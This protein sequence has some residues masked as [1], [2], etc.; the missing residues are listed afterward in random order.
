MVRFLTK[1]DGTAT[2]REGKRLFEERAKEIDDQASIVIIVAGRTT[3]LTGAQ[4]KAS[5]YAG[6]KDHAKITERSSVH[7][8]QIFGDRAR[9]EYSSEAE[10]F[11]PDLN[12]KRLVRD[13][14]TMDIQKIG[15]RLI[16]T[17]WRSELF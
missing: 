12:V 11:D 16:V 9:V 14:G 1:H 3:T 2:V 17:K 8:V 6:Y 5:A 15:D 4:Y 10:I 13:R 7:D